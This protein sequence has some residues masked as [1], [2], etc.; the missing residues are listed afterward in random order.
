VKSWKST[1]DIHLRLTGVL[2]HCCALHRST[3]RLVQPACCV[4]DGLAKLSL[5]QTR[6]SN[7]TGWR[8]R[9]DMAA[10]VVVGNLPLVV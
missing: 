5:V 8:W 2:V 4:V 9:G 1:S 6:E 10:G 7:W 3:K